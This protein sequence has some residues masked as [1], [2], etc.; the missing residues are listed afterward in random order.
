MVTSANPF[1]MC[2][3]AGHLWGWISLLVLMTSPWIPVL[4]ASLYQS[5]ASYP[6]LHLLFAVKNLTPEITG[7]GA[8]CGQQLGHWS[9]DRCHLFLFALLVPEWGGFCCAD[10]QAQLSEYRSLTNHVPRRPWMEFANAL[11]C[12]SDFP[13]FASPMPLDVTF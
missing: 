2:R 4:W 10:Q 11:C 7:G 3:G 12:V 5:E 1:K 13:T 6:R 9:W 8:G